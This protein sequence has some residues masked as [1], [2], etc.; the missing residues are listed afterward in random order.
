MIQIVPEYLNGLQHRMIYHQD[1]FQAIFRHLRIT[2][3]GHWRLNRCNREIWRLQF[4][5][6][7][8][9]LYVGLQNV[10]HE[11]ALGV[12]AIIFLEIHEQANYHHSCLATNLILWIEE[13][14]H[15]HHLALNSGPEFLFL[16]DELI[17]SLPNRISVIDELNDFLEV[18]RRISFDGVD[19]NFIKQIQRS[20]KDIAGEQFRSATIMLVKSLHNLKLLV[21]WMR[22]QQRLQILRL[23]AIFG[24]QPFQKLLVANGRLSLLWLRRFRSRLV[25][26]KK[27]KIMKL[28]FRE[29]LLST[30]Q[31]LQRWIMIFDFL[32]KQLLLLLLL[33]ELLDVLR[34][35]FVDVCRN[36]REFIFRLA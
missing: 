6:K 8:L 19:G 26:L 14:V 22:W 16:D 1:F 3:P 9:L 24:L 36:F 4:K 32:L 11:S 7:A 17:C 23:L 10:S 30:H 5:L 15:E 2:F 20:L 28:E 31:F 27:N 33:L 25:K 34:N 35:H 12:K 18:L 21:V 29:I 13:K